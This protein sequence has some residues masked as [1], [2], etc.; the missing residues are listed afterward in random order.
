MVYDSSRSVV[1]LCGGVLNPSTAVADTWT[2]D[3]VRWTEV[4][5]PGPNPPRNNPGIAHDVV[6]GQ[7]VLFGGGLLVSC[8]QSNR[9]LRDTWVW[10]GNTWTPAA[11]DGPVAREGAAL[12]Y[13]SA[14][15]EIVLF[16]GGYGCGTF[17]SDTWTWSGS[18][19][20]QHAATRD[21]RNGSSTWTDGAGFAY[22][23][24]G[25]N[26]IYR[27]DLW[28]WTGD[29]WQ[30]LSPAAAPSGRYGSGAAYDAERGEA[31]LFGGNNQ[32]LHFADTW[33]FDGTTWTEQS[34]PGPTARTA[35]VM[36]YDA[37]RRQIV[38]FGGAFADGTRS[39]ETWIW[40]AR[41]VITAHPAAATA[42]A[43]QDAA[44]GVT[45]EGNGPF[46]YQWRRDGAPLSDDC[47][48][49]GAT[50]ASLS[51]QSVR[52]D[53]GA[54]YDCVVSNACGEVIA[55][56]ASLRVSELTGDLDCNCQ[57]DLTDLTLLLSNFGTFCAQ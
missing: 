33:V 55:E 34:G 31:V 10:D 12:A 4:V 2:W 36:V 9:F 44:F 27:N 1:L 25:Y 40:S 6:S 47:R 19:W 32:T 3:G 46:T 26:G 52:A 15:G 22:Y 54:L 45:A 48:I 42:C 5:T 28:R 56:G 43:G 53:D 41:P 50:S 29:E 18:Q 17:P 57:V 49:Q 51:I 11:T 14:Q 30:P 38:L 20:V 37:A 16:G 13:T 35:H 39:A 23:F 7:T 8:N 21:G 24:G